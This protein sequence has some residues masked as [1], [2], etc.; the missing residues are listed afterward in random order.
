MRK[1]RDVKEVMKLDTG[2][3]KLTVL[4]DITS[5][6]FSSI[7][8]DVRSSAYDILEERS[9]EVVKAIR[10][11]EETI[12]IESYSSEQLLRLVAFIRILREQAIAEGRDRTM[13][14]MMLLRGV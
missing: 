8:D 11:F 9:S 5:E 4:F 10:F 7:F 1:M 2:E 3:V 6:E 12:G 13:M 14:A